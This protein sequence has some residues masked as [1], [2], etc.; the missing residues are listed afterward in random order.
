MTTFQ[1]CDY[2]YRGAVVTVCLSQG[3]VRTALGLPRRDR[4]VCLD[5]ASRTARPGGWRGQ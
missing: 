2:C 1:R 5:H 3:I 4:R